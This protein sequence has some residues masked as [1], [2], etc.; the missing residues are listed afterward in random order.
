LLLDHPSRCVVWAVGRGVAGLGH[1]IYKPTCFILLHS[2]FIYSLTL[3]WNKIMLGFNFNNSTHAN[4]L[5]LMLRLVYPI[6][7][8]IAKVFIVS[9]RLFCRSQALGF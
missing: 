2:Y 4:L 1:T 3:Q 7:V 6:V 9:R 8:I 5:K